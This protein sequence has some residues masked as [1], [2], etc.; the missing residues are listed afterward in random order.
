MNE[1]KPGAENE[2][3]QRG[4]IPPVRVVLWTVLILTVVTV[5]AATLWSTL[6]REP[7]QPLPDL[8]QVPAFTLIGRDGRT[9]TLAGLTGKPFVIDF[10]YTRCVTSCPLMTAA[11][12]KVGD[13]LVE[14]KDFRRVSVSVDPSY[15][16]PKVLT[17]YAKIHGAPSTWWFLTGSPQAIVDLM[18]KGFHLGVSSTTGDP[19]NPV[20]H[21]TRMVLVDGRGKI[22]GYYRGL[23]PE[24]IANLNR[25]LR[26]LARSG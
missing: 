21:S 1:M 24:Q 16:T 23:E 20:S 17:A 18:S 6:H 15:D 11:M 10:I 22:R 9:V 26:R 4:G 25:D 7:A 12:T 19:R 3:G 13:G 8:G 2:G 5:A 14:G